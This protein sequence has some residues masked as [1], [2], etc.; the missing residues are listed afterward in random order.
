MTKTLKANSIITTT[1]AGD[2]ITFTVKDAGALTLD[3]SKV[4][5]VN[6][7]RAMRH[8]FIQRVSDKAAISRDTKTGLSATPA[9]KLAAMKTL[10]DHF[11]SG[12]EEWSPAR[13]ERAAAVVIIGLDPLAIAAVCEVTGKDEPAIRAFIAKGAVDKGITELAYLAALTTSARVKP[14]LERMQADAA[15]EAELDG[16]D[17]LDGID[18]E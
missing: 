13:A 6:A 3:L 4:S 11:M 1:V 2:I 12:T 16:D 5:P 17:L 7:T 10:V 9:E 18:G 14:V 8:G 15:L